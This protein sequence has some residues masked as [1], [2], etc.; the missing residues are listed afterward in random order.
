[1]HC[2]YSEEVSTSLELIVFD[3]ILQTGR[4]QPREPQTGHADLQ[5]ED[6]EEEAKESDPE[7]E[8][9]QDPETETDRPRKKI[10]ADNVH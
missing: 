9:E 10:R 1:M 4:E 6:K 7:C 3:L 8:P 5:E 2:A